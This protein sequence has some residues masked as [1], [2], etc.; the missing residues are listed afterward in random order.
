MDKLPS[1]AEIGRRVRERRKAEGL[2]QKDL[3][4][5]TGIGHPSII[6]LEKGTGRLRLENAWTLLSVLGLAETGGTVSLDVEGK[7]YDAVYSL[8]DGMITVVSDLGR[9]T[10][11]I[12]GFEGNER[13]LAERLLSELV[14]ERRGE[15]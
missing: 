12:G 10:A 7:S 6:A 5:L 9:K 14:A 3:A 2:S 11:Q 13:S 8:G 1:L 4:G 15:R